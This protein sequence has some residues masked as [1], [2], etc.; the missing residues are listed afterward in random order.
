RDET[1]ARR[2]WPVTVGKI[3]IPALQRDRAQLFA[4]A[5]TM[6]DAGARWWPDADFERSHIKPQQDERYE[7]DPWEDVIRHYLVLKEQVTV[8]EVAKAAI[9]LETPK[10][11]KAEQ[12]RITSTLTN[13][14]WKRGPRGGPNGTRWW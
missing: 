14:R 11:G 9:G 6:F 10:I 5:R 13:L 3:D 1:G 7:A 2:T 8:T 12:N 4:E